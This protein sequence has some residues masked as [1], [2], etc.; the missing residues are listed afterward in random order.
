MTGKIDP[1]FA[2]HPEVLAMR[3]Q[4]EEFMNK[5]RAEQQAVKSLDYWKG[6]LDAIRQADVHLQCVGD[7]RT[8]RECRKAVLRLCGIGYDPREVVPIPAWPPE[9]YILASLPALKNGERT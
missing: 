7:D 1:L 8:V 5:L 9:E 4:S 2:D 3:K 6:Y